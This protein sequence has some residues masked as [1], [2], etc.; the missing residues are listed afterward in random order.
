MS[1]MCQVGVQSDIYPRN[2]R[3]SGSVVGV[4]VIETSE[5]MTGSGIGEVEKI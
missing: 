2:C 4:L 5:K 1:G 3:D